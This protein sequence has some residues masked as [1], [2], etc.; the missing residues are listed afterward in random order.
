MLR[1]AFGEGSLR[2]IAGDKSDETKR[3]ALERLLVAGEV[4]ISD[5]APTGE[6]RFNEVLSDFLRDGGRGKTGVRHQGG[7]KK[8]AGNGGMHTAHGRCSAGCGW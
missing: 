4:D 7:H 1:G 5:N 6:V 8:A 3:A 2:G